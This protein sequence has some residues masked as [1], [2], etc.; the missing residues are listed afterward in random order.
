[1]NTYKATKYKNKWAVL[2]CKTR[3]FYF[4]G[5]GKAFCENKARDLNKE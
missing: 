4:I 3:V 5:C 2:D 1:M